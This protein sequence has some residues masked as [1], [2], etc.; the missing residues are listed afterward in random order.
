MARAQYIVPR[1]APRG[2]IF[3]FAHPQ[4]YLPPQGE[5]GWLGRRPSLRTSPAVNSHLLPT[6]ARVD[7]AFERGEGPWLFT[8]EGERYLD[9]TAGVAV[10]GLGHAHP[11]LVAALAAQAQKV[12]HVSNLFRI[13]E[14]ERLAARL[15]AEAKN[16]QIL[17]DSK[18][19]AAIEEL[20]E[21]EPVG[22][23]VLKGFHRPIQAFNVSVRA[24][25]Q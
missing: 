7:L 5:D 24:L 17:I 11:H 22:E 15:C 9:F 4:I 6:Y 10:N 1:A 20:A 23:L 16:G 14:A 2:G 8:T 12:W 13:P 3:C 19:F 25:Q 18:V 21:T